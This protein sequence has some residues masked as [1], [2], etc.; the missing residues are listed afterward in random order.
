MREDPGGMCVF[1]VGRRAQVLA[2]EL[3]WPGPDT[4]ALEIAARRHGIGEIGVADDIVAAKK[5]PRG[6]GTAVDARPLPHWR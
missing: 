1:R 4:E 2:Q 3:G 6:G 5:S